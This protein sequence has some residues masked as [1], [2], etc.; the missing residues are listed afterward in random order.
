VHELFGMLLKNF[1]FLLKTPKYIISY[2]IQCN[3]YVKQNMNKIT[4][5]S[6][7]NKN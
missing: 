7:V 2:E 5:H 4:E 1:K 3:V 6:E